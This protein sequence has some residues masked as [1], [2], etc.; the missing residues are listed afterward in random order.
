M[1]KIPEFEFLVM[2]EKI[3]FAYDFFSL[4]ISDFNL[5]FMWKL[6]PLWKSHPLLSQQPPSKSWVPVKPLLFENLVEG[7]MPSAEREGCTHYA[8]I[9]IFMVLASSTSGYVLSCLC[10]MFQWKTNSFKLQISMAFT[11]HMHNKKVTPNW[12]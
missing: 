2:T 8:L 7:S 9:Y 6:Q 1:G 11:E 10:T 4:N 5:F 3:I 12:I